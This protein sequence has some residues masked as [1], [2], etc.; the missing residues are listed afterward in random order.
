MRFG[1][2]LS[3][4]IVSLL[5][6]SRLPS[7]AQTN[8]N[9]PIRQW[10]TYAT[11][12]S[13][14]SSPEWAAIQATGE[15]DTFDC[16]D[17]GTAWASADSYGEASLTV[18][19]DEPVFPIQVN[20]HQTYTPG[21][22]TSIELLQVNGSSVQVPQS[23]DP[24]TDCPRVFSLN[25][26]LPD[27]G[28]VDGVT[29]YLNQDIG[30]SWNEIDAV[31]LVGYKTTE[32]EAVT[33]DAETTAEPDALEPEVTSESNASLE[34]VLIEPEP[35]GYEVIT[36]ENAASVQRV[37]LVYGLPLVRDIAFSPRG[38]LLAAAVAEFDNNVDA[39][40][41]FFSV[42]DLVEQ[43]RFSIPL[44]EEYGY[45]SPILAFSPDGT[46]LA[47]GH[48]RYLS[49]WDVSTGQPLYTIEVDDDYRLGLES[50]SFSPDGLL[51]A[52]TGVTNP[53]GLLDVMTGS[54]LDSPKTPQTSWALYADFYP[55]ITPDGEFLLAV[56]ES[57]STEDE[58]G[59]SF[60]RVVLYAIRP[61]GSWDVRSI[62]TRPDLSAYNTDCCLANNHV[63]FSPE[64][65]FVAHSSSSGIRL[66]NIAEERLATVLLPYQMSEYQDEFEAICLDWSPN[67]RLIV[68]TEDYTEPAVVFD[69]T[70]GQIISL[71]TQHGLGYVE[72][73]ELEFSPDGSLIAISGNQDN[74]LVLYGIPRPVNAFAVTSEVIEG[75]LP[76]EGSV[77][78]EGV[79]GE[80]ITITVQALSGSLDPSVVLFEI[81]SSDDEEDIFIERNDNHNSD[82][83]NLTFVDARINSLTLRK[84]GT[85]LLKI[86]GYGGR[87]RLTIDRIPPMNINSE[88]ITS[89]DAPGQL[90]YAAGSDAPKLYRMSTS[91]LVNPE[92]LTNSNTSESSMDVAADGSIV[93]TRLNSENEFWEVILIHPDGE[94]VQLTRDMGNNYRPTFSPD[95]TQILFVS[96]R[97]GNREIYLMASDGSNQRR[98]TSNSIVDDFPAWSPD[99]S[100]ILFSSNRTGNADLYLMDTTGQISDRLTNNAD[101]EVD[102]SWSPDGSQIVFSVLGE[103]N[104]ADILVLDLTNNQTTMLTDGGLNFSPTWS[105]D[106]HYIAFIS[107]RNGG[108]DIYIVE[109]DGSNVQ[110]ITQT[111]ELEL[112]VRWVNVP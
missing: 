44:V 64:G 61:G 32:T 38:N 88:T 30:G 108:Q 46:K 95:G 68:A 112:F 52:F 73:E 97:D 15:P 22:I 2:L 14:Y 23:S 84:T 106:G 40:V 39:E 100:Q 45:I 41:I 42:P 37:N 27:I 51:L 8:S 18:Y 35:T 16:G 81:T 92:M 20:I 43:S 36:P 70:N 12:S 80:T 62:F 102:I 111:T 74:T 77:L 13:E 60:T 26:D 85:Y 21:S 71:L 99:G 4:L 91:N 17:I 58:G 96:D 53:L 1:V 33:L 25:I 47:V 54:L 67:G 86:G 101:T 104:V 87:Y 5:I 31:E 3:I 11:A 28:L 76:G 49:L 34:I 69:V 24:V 19:F 57:A 63:H 90:I 75:E 48:E 98:L 65:N 107:D 79:A 93:L 29:I 94:S 78:F 10:A 72:P 66:W 89:L 82:D 103:D 6:S 56:S 109:A 55:G 83:F 9:E 7:H 50:L 59:Y 110:R 105:P